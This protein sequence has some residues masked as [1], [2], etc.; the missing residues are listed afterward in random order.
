MESNK[1][2][3]GKEKTSCR[4]DEGEWH[5]FVQ[6]R[7]WRWAATHRVGTSLPPPSLSPWISPVW[8]TLVDASKKCIG[9]FV[10]ALSQPYVTLPYGY[11]IITVFAEAGSPLTKYMNSTR[12]FFIQI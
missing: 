12:A 10:T 9:G 11:H 3:R 8:P 6:R 4:K 5:I 2:S 7:K 1:P